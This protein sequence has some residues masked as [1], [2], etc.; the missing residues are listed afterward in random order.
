MEKKLGALFDVFDVVKF[1]G[2]KTLIMA[3]DRSIME[4]ER[5]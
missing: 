1:Y 5:E 2:S 3:V 4:G